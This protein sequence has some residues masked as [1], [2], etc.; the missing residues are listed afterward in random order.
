MTQLVR[1]KNIIKFD[2]TRTKVERNIMPNQCELVQKKKDE[3]S[4]SKIK[5]NLNKTGNK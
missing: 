2:I 1:K 4:G 3:R 5:K